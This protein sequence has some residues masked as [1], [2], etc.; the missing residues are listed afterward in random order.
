MAKKTEF[1]KYILSAGEIGAYTVCPEAWRLS[2][3]EKV[4]TLKSKNVVLGIDMHKRWAKGYDEAV[5]FRREVKL[6]II[7]V[8]V[9]VVLH[10]IM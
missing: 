3:V 8:A 7:L 1:G 6:L 4:D 9:A 10:L 2:A 5:Y